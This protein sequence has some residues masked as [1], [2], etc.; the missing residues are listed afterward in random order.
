MQC[1]SLENNDSIYQAHCKDCD[2]IL[3][4]RDPQ[5]EG[6]RLQKPYLAL[7]S[8]RDSTTRSHDAAHWFSCYLNQATET[9]GVRKFVFPT[10]PH[11][12]WVFSTN[13]AYSSLECSEPKQAMKVLFKAREEGQDV[14]TL[15]AGNLLIETL[16]LS[17][18]LEEL[19]YQVLQ[20]ENAKLPE[21]LQSL[22]GWQV[23]VLPVLY[24]S[25]STKA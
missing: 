4:Y 13:L 19:F 18:S 7:S 2:T 16:T 3:G 22:M 1:R 21:S 24:S 8:Q 9:Q 20:Q 25:G 15:R 12:I 10:L 14:E 11:E 17:P 5:T 6:I 23:A